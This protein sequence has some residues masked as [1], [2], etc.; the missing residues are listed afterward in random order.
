MATKKVRK[1]KTEPEAGSQPEAGAASRGYTFRTGAKGEVARL[2]LANPDL[3]DDELLKLPEFDAAVTKYKIKHP[4][5][6]IRMARKAMKDIDTTNIR[7]TQVGATVATPTSYAAEVAGASLSPASHF[8]ALA[9]TVESI[10]TMNP[11]PSSTPKPVLGVH[12][13]FNCHC[14]GLAVVD[15]PRD[16]ESYY[17]YSEQRRLKFGS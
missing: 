16:K 7:W 15:D 3:K 6:R 11:T 2:I 10:A 1:V 9:N 5:D 8:Q 13:F 4:K 14:G 12:P 17:C